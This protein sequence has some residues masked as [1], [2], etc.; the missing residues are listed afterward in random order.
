MAAL[1]WFKQTT[2]KDADML[3]GKARKGDFISEVVTSGELQAKNSVS[4]MGPREMRNYRINEVKIQDLIAEG[5]LV[6]KGDYV[7]RLDPSQLSNSRKDLENEFTKTE[8]QLEQVKLDTA[9]EMRAKRDELKNLKF[10]LEEREIELKYSEYEPPAVQRQA[11]INLE[12]AKRA[13]HNALQAYGLKQAQAQAKVREVAAALA[14]QRDNM[15]KLQALMEEFTIKAPEDGMLIYGRDWGGSKLK[16]GAT[17]NSWNPL[18]AQ[19]PDLSVMV[20]RTYV[21]EVDISKVKKD[22]EVVVTIDAFPSKLLKGKV[23]YVA[24]VGEERP[25]VSGKSFEVSI[26]LHETD[27]ALRPGMTTGNRIQVLTIA[28]VVSV[29]LEAINSRE[30]IYFVAVK[31]GLGHELREVA[32]GVANDME[33]CV[34]Q[35]LDGTEEV[36][37]VLP[38]TAGESEI[39]RLEK[40]PKAKDEQG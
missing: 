19:L 25:G 12:K 35:G 20:S 26:Q 38:S 1:W 21:N 4:I 10:A 2:N 13:Y 9:I 5:T 34:N 33:V 39:V 32:L 30:G 14:I 40:T 31:T 24:N 6:K 7:G 28:N 3:W 15:E 23:V 17:I 27:P 36:L 18:I 11:E 8:S 16:V 29:P 22:M 37:L